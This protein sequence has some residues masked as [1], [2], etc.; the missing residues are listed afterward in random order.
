LTAAAAPPATIEH[1]AALTFDLDTLSRDM[2]RP[3]LAAADARRLEEVSFH[4]VVPRIAEWLDRINVRATFFTIGEYA[5]RYPGTVRQLSDAGHEIA[6]HTHSHPRDFSTLTRIEVRRELDAA[7]ETLTVTSGVEPR[8]FRAP[9]FTTSPALI[10]A[11]GELGYAY[12][13]SIVPSWTYTTL[14]HVYR[15]AGLA[16]AG[17][18]YPE[19]FACVR[20]PQVPYRISPTRRF[21]PDD[22]ASLLE[23][24]ITTAS[25]LQWPLIYGVHVRAYGRMRQRM[26]RAASSRPFVLMVFHDLEF[27]TRE[28]LGGL[29][30]GV[31]TG[32]HVAEPLDVRL[33]RIETWIARTRATHRFAP[34]RDIAAAYASRPA[35]IAV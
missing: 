20:A 3:A 10:E 4:V 35:S 30:V 14:K 23:I 26:E 22:A 9:G 31:L 7:H 12:D 34:L 29:P 15:L 11:L 25:A 13:S 1:L 19:S 27:A 5:R 21:Q 16:S 2:Y 24:P 18:L 17:Y 33:A 6:S 28:D 8:G 32:P